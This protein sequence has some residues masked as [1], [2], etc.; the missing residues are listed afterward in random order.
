MQAHFVTP[1][2]PQSYLTDPEEPVYFTKLYKQLALI[3]G[4]WIFKQEELVLDLS[5]KICLEI[6]ASA[7]W[8]FFIILWLLFAYEAIE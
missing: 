2:V 3:I 7:T 8:I 4:I 5:S 1:H 6:I